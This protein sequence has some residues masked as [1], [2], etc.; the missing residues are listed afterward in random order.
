MRIIQPRANGIFNSPNFDSL[1][2]F[3]LALHLVPKLK[4][5]PS[6]R[7]MVTRRLFEQ[8]IVDKISRANRPVGHWFTNGQAAKRNDEEEY[9]EDDNDPFQKCLFVHF[10]PLLSD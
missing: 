7:E 5:F 2:K 6:A 10:S 8:E 3:S 9:D 1:S 4:F